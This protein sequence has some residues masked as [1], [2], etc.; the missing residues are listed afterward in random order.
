M[1][2]KHFGAR[3]ARLEDPALLTGQ[4]RFVDDIQI[5]G[6][7]H[8]AFVRSPHAHARLRKIDAGAARAMTSVHAV[9]TADDMPP[10]IATGMIP[11]LVPNP[12]IR[13]PRTQISLARDEVCYVGQTVAVVVADNRYLAEDAANAVEVD[14]ELLP[15]VGDA[16]DSVEP[17]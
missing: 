16:P 12:A 9:L 5:A 11:M 8:A 1:G 13:T 15:A 14:Y 17:G 7:L 2:A 4:G 10:R 6:T 3:I